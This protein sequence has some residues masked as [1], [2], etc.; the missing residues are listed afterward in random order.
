MVVVILTGT[1]NKARCQSVKKATKSVLG[2]GWDGLILTKYE[3]LTQ[4]TAVVGGYA[5]MGF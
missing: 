2:G 3:T 1:K 5:P 4:E